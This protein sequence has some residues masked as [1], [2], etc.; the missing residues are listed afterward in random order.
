MAQVDPKTLFGYN[1]LSPYCELFVNIYKLTLP[2]SNDCCRDNLKYIQKEEDSSNLNHTFSSDPKHDEM[3]EGEIEDVE[4]PSTLKSAVPNNSPNYPDVY[5]DDKFKKKLPFAKKKKGLMHKLTKKQIRCAAGANVGS[6]KQSSGKKF[7]KYD[8]LDVKSQFDI[9]RHPLRLKWLQQLMDFMKKRGTPII[10][11]PTVPTSVRLNTNDDLSTQTPLDLWS[12]HTNVVEEEYASNSKELDNEGWKKVA[13]RMKVPISK[14][15]ALRGIYRQYLRPF[16][17]RSLEHQ[18][19]QFSPSQ[20][21]LNKTTTKVFDPV[22][23]EFHQI[24]SRKVLL[25]TPSP[26]RQLQAN[27]SIVPFNNNEKEVEN[28][29]SVKQRLGKKKGFVPSVTGFFN[30][31]N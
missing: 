31:N 11:S 19:T 16:A 8:T 3:E 27:S 21:Q 10:N 13:A 12:L 4:S 26:S 2:N 5:Q 30:F 28:K 6:N 25:P 20:T 18:E 22:K 15:F 24:K 1:P 14:S 23:K 9:N 17:K 29:S 7:I